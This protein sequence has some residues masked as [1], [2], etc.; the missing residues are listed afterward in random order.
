MLWLS[1]FGQHCHS[2]ISEIPM[3]ETGVSL[4]EVLPHSRTQARPNQ[5][6]TEPPAGSWGDVRWH[7]FAWFSRPKLGHQFSIRDL[8]GFAQAGAKLKIWVE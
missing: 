3:E 5:I 2:G 6:S 7:S 8:K 4:S 1:G